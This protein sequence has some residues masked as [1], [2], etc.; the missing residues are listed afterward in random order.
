MEHP[1][2]LARQ[3]YGN[4]DNSIPYA[5]K[6]RHLLK[7]WFEMDGLVKWKCRSCGLVETTGRKQHA[8]D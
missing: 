3:L 6:C 7:D 4:P 8:V 5:D 2:D 1:G